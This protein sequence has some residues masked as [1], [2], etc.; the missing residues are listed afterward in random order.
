M[1]PNAKYPVFISTQIVVTIFT[2]K[3]C[4]GIKDCVKINYNYNFYR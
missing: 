2:C 3:A 1:S 4:I